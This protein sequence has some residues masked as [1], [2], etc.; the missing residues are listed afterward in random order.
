M[1]RYPYNFEIPRLISLHKVYSIISMIAILVTAFAG[2]LGLAFGSF[3]NV[4]AT[5][6][7]EDESIVA[8]RSHCRTCGRPLPWHETVPLA[9]WVALRG[10]CRG[11]GAW[12]GWRLPL[13]EFGLGF[14]WAVAAWQA[15]PAMVLPGWTGTSIFDAVLFALTKMILSWLLVLLAVLDAEHYWLPDRL[16]I[17]GS[18][19]GL[20]F[21]FLKF[22]ARWIWRENPLDSI[23]SWELHRSYIYDSILHWTLGL[24]ALPLFLLVTRWAYR[25]VRQREGVGLGDAKLM[26]LIAVWLGLDHSMLAFVLGVLLGT[27]IGI[28]MLFRKPRN[29]VDESWALTRL[30]LGTCLAIG[31]IVSALW[32]T[33]L[34]H[35]YLEAAGF[36]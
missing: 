28:V 27:V 33:P 24:L 10:R 15:M 1:I 25:M 36:F 6:M 19:L 32:G 31:G 29:A 12:I 8:P 18:I 16:T 3:L 2:L 23:S 20:P 11:C 7:P 30:P 17:G 5:R 26:L 21:V 4:C 9:S 35:A 34:I 13:V 14:A 22:A